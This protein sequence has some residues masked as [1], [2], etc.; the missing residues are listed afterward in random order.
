MLVYDLKFLGSS[1]YDADNLT[2]ETAHIIIDNEAAIVIAKCNKDTAGN[3]HVARRYHYVRQGTAMKEHVFEWIG[4]K[5]QLADTLTKAGIP[6][7]VGHLWSIQLS[8]TDTN[9]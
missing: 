6:T 8:E 4:T 9:D 7:T 2:Y 3:H 5:Y 1:T